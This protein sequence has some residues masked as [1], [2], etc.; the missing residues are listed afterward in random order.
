MEIMD[1]KDMLTLDLPDIEGL[2]NADDFAQAA[3]ADSADSEDVS[4]EYDPM[5]AAE[6]DIPMPVLSE[7]DGSDL[8]SFD[9]APAPANMSGGNVREDIG[10][11]PQLSEMSDMPFS[12]GISGA[13]GSTGQA[14]GNAGAASGG[15]RIYSPMNGNSSYSPASGSSGQNTYSPVSGGTGISNAPFGQQGRSSYLDIMDEE[16]QLAAKG[17][18]IARIIGNI[19]LVIS[20]LDGIAGLLS[21]N[22]RAILG[23]VY[24]IY[25]CIQFKKGSHNSRY[26]LGAGCVLTVINGIVSVMAVDSTTDFVVKYT[27]SSAL[28][29][30]V[31]LIVLI[32]VFLFAVLAY[33][34]LLDKRVAA[35]CER[36]VGRID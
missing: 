10:G 17:E 7:M 14:A 11:L 23:A 24:H 25:F 18:R 16:V 26:W 15:Q 1:D 36:N 6:E 29:T 33:F 21:I 27:G 2:A 13:Q 30:I 31:Q 9:A 32:P 20:I 8:G 34:Y 4:C 5:A 19:T 3:Q 22:I 12:R 28:I 35:Y